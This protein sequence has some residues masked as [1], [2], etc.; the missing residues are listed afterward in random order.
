MTR[1]QGLGKTVESI[2]VLLHRP[3]HPKPGSDDD[4][5]M[6]ASAQPLPVPGGT[7]IVTPPAIRRQWQQ[8]VQ[9]CLTGLLNS[10]IASHHSD[11][12]DSPDAVF[13]VVLD[14]GAF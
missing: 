13:C 7:L 3:F 5:S 4:A 8:E 6:V 12:I 1:L 9:A 14:A 10:A 11:L 2:A